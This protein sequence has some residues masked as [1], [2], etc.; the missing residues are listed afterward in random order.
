MS[1][2]HRTD[3][4]AVATAREAQEARDERRRAE[5]LHRDREA[6]YRGARLLAQAEWRPRRA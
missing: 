2:R 4:Y 3:R 5:Q 6:A 1:M